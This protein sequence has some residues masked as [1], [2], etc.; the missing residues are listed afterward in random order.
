MFVQYRLPS[1]RIKKHLID[2]APAP[3]FPWFER[4]D[5]GV[6]ALMKVLSRVLV[7]RGIATCYVTADEAEAEMNPGVAYLEAVFA[8]LLVRVFEFDLIEM[9]AIF[10]HS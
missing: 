7:L 2:V 8:A 9:S 6:I 1:H 10:S 4:G 3:V 5:D